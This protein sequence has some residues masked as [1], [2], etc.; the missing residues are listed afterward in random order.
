MISRQ[1]MRHKCKPSSHCSIESIHI[2]YIECNN[3]YNSREIIQVKTP[4][5]PNWGLSEGSTISGYC[6]PLFLS[7]IRWEDF[8]VQAHLVLGQALCSGGGGGD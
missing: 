6:V 8:S 5:Y 4:A 7:R 2:E 3:I 1:L